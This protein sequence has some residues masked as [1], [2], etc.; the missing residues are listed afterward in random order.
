LA[1]KGLGGGVVP[2]AEYAELMCQQARA[3]DRRQQHER[4]A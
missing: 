1:L 2:S 3:R 4:L